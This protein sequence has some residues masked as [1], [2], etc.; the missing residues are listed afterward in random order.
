MGYGKAGQAVAH[1]LQEDSRCSLQWVARKRIG[2]ASH[3]KNTPIPLISSDQ[4]WNAWLDE[5]PVD[6][7]VDFSHPDAVYQYGPAMAERGIMLVS[8][9]S[10]YQPEHLAFLAQLGQQTQ[11]LCSPNITLGI[12]FLILA[13]K[14]LR[15]IAP[16][17]DVAILEQ[18]F[19]EKEEI[20]GTARRIAATL[21]VEEDQITSLRLGG[22]VGHHEV[23]F[24][25]PYQTV[26]LIHNSIKRE[27][28]GTGAV[29]AL[30]ELE[31][32][33]PGMYNFDELLERRMRQSLLQGTA[34]EGA[35]DPPPALA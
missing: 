22:I 34:C 19:K 6:A 28:F 25:F 29:F 13:A 2:E 21:S 9:N 8:A 20:S 33:P 23:I 32:C 14:L 24:G 12:N 7:I 18:H 11:V 30:H 4:D 27:A 16:F 15:N 5:H 10:A 3:V 31:T 17:A 35:G 26:R 1:V